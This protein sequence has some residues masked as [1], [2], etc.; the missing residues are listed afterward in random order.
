M[1]TTYQYR[2][3]DKQGRLLEGKLDADSGALVA[4]KLR[5]MG[6]VPVDITEQADSSLNREIKIPGLSG[7]VS[8]KDVAVFSRQFS[9]MI[10]SGLTMLRGLHILEDQTENKELAR[11]IGEVRMDVERGSS[12]SQA[13]A[14][15]PKVFDRL[16]IS[17][18]RAGETGGVLDSVLQRLATTIEK[19]VE[20]TRKIKSAMT[21]PVAVMGLVLMMVSAMLIFVVPMFEDLYSEL[22]GTLPLPTRIL[23][24]VSGILT[25]YIVVVLILTVAGAVGF[26][27]WIASDSGRARWD[28]VKLRVPVFG[29]LVQKTSLSRFA[30]TLAALLRAGV[31][32]LESL[33]IVHD[34]VGNAVAARAIDDTKLAV[35]QGESIAAPLESHDVFPSMVVQMMAVGEETGALDEMLDKI[36][37]FYDDEIEA[38]VTALTSLLEPLLIVVLGGSVGGMVVALYMPMFNIINLIE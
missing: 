31:P 18:V 34:T 15:H 9:T 21:Y 33:D 20:L 4:S 19:Q 13:L 25:S 12:L 37:D 29:T 27:R 32:I 23:I 8:K 2:V 3:R 24:G 26:R 1:P 6:Y 7:R 11:V 38:T 16:Y 36:A 22:G 35:K 30:R 14:E 10:N 28:A 5:E 17:M